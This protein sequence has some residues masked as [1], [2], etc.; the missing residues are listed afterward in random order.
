[1]MPSFLFKARDTG[2]RTQQGTLAAASAGAVVNQLRERGWLV[3]DVRDGA[4]AR[5]RRNFAPWAGPAQ[6]AAGAVG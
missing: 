5:D 2:G 1:M 6:L 4:A 3:L